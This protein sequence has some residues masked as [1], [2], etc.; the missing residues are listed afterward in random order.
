MGATDWIRELERDRMQKD[1]F[2]KSHPQSP[3]PPD[4]QAEFDGLEYYPFDPDYRF[5]LE[6][7][8]HAEKETLTM[9]YAGGGA[10]DF[11]HW[12]EFRFTVY[13]QEQS[14]QGYKNDPGE[15]R[16]FLL[17]KDAT[18]GDET[19]G[20]GRY[21]DLDGE[22]DRDPAGF[23]RGFCVVSDFAEVQYKCTAM[24]NPHGESGV[25]WDD[26]ALGIEWPVDD[27][28]LS[29]KDR[30][31]AQARKLGVQDVTKFLK[32]GS[33]GLPRNMWDCCGIAVGSL[34]QAINN[35]HRTE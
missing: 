24:Y 13:G 2:L 6:L 23:A 34:R 35:Y 31:L 4:H 21:L 11:V 25:R 16:L 3:I 8:E 32:E 22:A 30:S 26:P 33:K 17:F 27:P 14:I 12:G 20:A 5:E 1:M 7:N 18:S 15:N 10:R 9:D 19:Y 28:I 29:E